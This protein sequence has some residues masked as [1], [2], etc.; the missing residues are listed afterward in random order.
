VNIEYHLD[1]V[2]YRIGHR[3]KLLDGGEH[4]TSEGEDF[5]IL[6]QTPAHEAPPLF[7]GLQAGLDQRGSVRAGFLVV[8]VAHHTVA[9]PPTEERVDGNAQDFALDV[10][11]RYVHGR[12]RRRNSVPGGAEASPKE[13]LERF[14][15]AAHRRTA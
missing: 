2:S 6:G 9:G 7:L 14:S 5:A 12:D 11:Q 15:Q 3:R 10:P 4:A 8:R 1:L 13:Q